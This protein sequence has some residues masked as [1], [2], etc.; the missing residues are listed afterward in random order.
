MS[1]AAILLTGGAARRLGTD[2]ATLELDGERLVDR[3]VGV[4]TAVAD[5]VVEVGTGASGLVAVRE[6]PPGAG[7][8]A[9]FAAGLAALADRGVTDGGVLLVAVDQ[10]GLTPGLLA[11]LRDHPADGAVV[12]VAAGRRQ[13]L[14]AR[15]PVA[16]RPVVE[17]LLAAGERSLRALL[18]RIP[19][20]EL[21]ESAWLS[22][23]GVDAFADLDQPADL[24]RTGWHPP[25]GP[26]AAPTR[27]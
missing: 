15:F 6:D 2:K 18:E 7:P 11:L 17:T 22:V 5:P 12:P 4:V 20:T 13:P 23:A 16:V 14:A 24:A 21:D 10:P 19:V 1:V 3:M 26:G 27:R 8:L 25:A 9:A